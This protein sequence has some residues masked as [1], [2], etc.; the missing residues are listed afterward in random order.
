MKITWRGK[1]M[2]GT[3]KGKGIKITGRGLRKGNDRMIRTRKGEGNKM[4]W[5]GEGGRK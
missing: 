5:N 2:I 4:N 3:R 1:G